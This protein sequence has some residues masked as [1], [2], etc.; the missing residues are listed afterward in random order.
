MVGTIIRPA[1]L[2]N[3]L[4][5]FL[6]KQVVSQLGHDGMFIRHV[7]HMEVECI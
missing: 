7:S 6:N 5:I 2:N 1:I 4:V 3:Q